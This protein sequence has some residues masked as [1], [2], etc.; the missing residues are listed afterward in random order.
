MLSNFLFTLYRMTLTF[1]FFSQ[2]TMLLTL[3][4][5]MLNVSN[6]QNHDMGCYY[7]GYVPASSCICVQ[8][9]SHK[10]LAVWEWLRMCECV[11]E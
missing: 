5:Q 11:N 8:A 2:N 10:G 4:L 6:L 3:I 1:P 7:T 9:Y